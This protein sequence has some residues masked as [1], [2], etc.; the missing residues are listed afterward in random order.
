MRT[1]G[2]PGYDPVQLEMLAAKALLEADHGWR[3]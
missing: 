3:S 2:E 1:S